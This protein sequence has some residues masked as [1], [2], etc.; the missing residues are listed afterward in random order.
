MAH[1]KKLNEKPLEKDERITDEYEKIL[2]EYK[3]II[4][5]Q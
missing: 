1:I 5:A 4:K 2:G 3:L